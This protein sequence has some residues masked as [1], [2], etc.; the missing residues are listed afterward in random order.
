MSEKEFQDQLAVQ[1]ALDTIN[2][3]PE[4]PVCHYSGFI[5]GKLYRSVKSRTVW[6]RKCDVSTSFRQ[7]HTYR[8]LEDRAD[9]I[10]RIEHPEWFELIREDR[11]Y[12]FNR[13]WV[14]TKHCRDLINF[15]EAFIEAWKD[16]HFEVREVFH[17]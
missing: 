10:C 1:I 16:K 9:E 14:K 8:A 5:D 7:S 17:T 6:T 2:Q 12:P 4:V 3:S 11:Y 13:P 15:R